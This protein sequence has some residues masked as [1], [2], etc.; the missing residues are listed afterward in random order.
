[1][2]LQSDWLEKLWS[3]RHSHGNSNRSFKLTRPFPFGY[4]IFHRGPA[5]T[6]ID[7][8]L[9]LASS[10][11]GRAGEEKEEN[12][13]NEEVEVKEVTERE[14]KE[15]IG[16]NL[17]ERERRKRRLQVGKGEENIL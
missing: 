2:S 16:A 8:T 17:R 5:A 13:K 4:S 9:K 7:C 12:E 15:S 11:L 6:Y 14:V 3:K 10:F 1:M